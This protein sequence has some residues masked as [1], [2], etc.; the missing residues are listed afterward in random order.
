MRECSVFEPTVRVRKKTEAVAKC[1]RSVECAHFSNSSFVLSHIHSICVGFGFYIV[2]FTL[3]QFS[4]QYNIHF[5]GH[6]FFFLLY[7]FNNLFCSTAVILHIYAIVMTD[8]L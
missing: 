8:L 6:H 1:T 3:K 2:S 5:L 4:I 7:S